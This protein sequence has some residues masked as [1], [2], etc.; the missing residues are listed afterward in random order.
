MRAVATLTMLTLSILVASCAPGAIGDASG[1]VRITLLSADVLDATVGDT[2]PAPIRIRVTGADG[3]PRTGVEVVFEATDG[4]R[5][6]PQRART[7]VEGVTVAHWVLAQRA[8]AQH[9][10]ASAGGSAVTVLAVCAVESPV[11]LVVSDGGD[12][13]GTP[14]AS[15]PRPVSVQVQGASGRGVPG[16]TVTFAVT[17]GSGGILAP[18]EAISDST[19]TVRTRI[20]LDATGARVFA[21]A[22]VRGVRPIEFSSAALTRAWTALSVRSVGMCIAERTPTLF[23]RGTLLQ[24]YPGGNVLG[25][26]TAMPVLPGQV[27]ML[28]SIDT[29][30]CALLTNGDLYCWGDDVLSYGAVGGTR[31]VRTPTLILGDVADFALETTHD[32]AVL[33]DGRGMCW[34]SDAVG[35]LG[36]GNTGTNRPASP[37]AVT[38]SVRW[39]AVVPLAGWVTAGIAVDGQLYRWGLNQTTNMATGVPEAVPNSPRLL[40]LTSNG[41]YAS[42]ETVCGIDVSNAAWCSGG[43]RFGQLGN[44]L[45]GV[46]SPFPALQAVG[47][48]HQFRHVAVGQQHV[49]GLRV[50]GR[51]LCWGTSAYLG[52][53]A[54]DVL[55]R[56]APLLISS[57]MTFSQIDARYAG[58]CGIG[59]DAEL[60][61]W[62]LEATVF[63]ILRPTPMRIPAP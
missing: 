15:L 32:C 19:G 14:G 47:G 9:A 5:V 31:I 56:T 35:S 36:R 21:I 34:G 48:G 38:G 16:I 29:R 30:S 49:C 25:S 23:C 62:G 4:G 45:V 7:D 24:D 61:C 41:M 42:F 8:G 26:L 58:T 28:R 39:R 20:T 27:S 2:V 54:S 40:E 11:R 44:G 51:V 6:S 12:Q 13:V 55:E 60:Y 3:R 57:P 43:N 53:G 33:R 10:S 59:T 46:P 50:D 52:I 37:A 22:Q 1:D 63:A 17:S 18:M